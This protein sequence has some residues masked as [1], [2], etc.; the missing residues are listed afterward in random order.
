MVPFMAWRGLC[1]RGWA[2]PGLRD[3]PL[4]RSRESRMA[5]SGS[6]GEGLWALSGVEVSAPFA[7]L[8][9]G[10]VMALSEP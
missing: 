3:W 1:R 7:V 10:C 5:L 4:L 6:C 8:G 2:C 9:V